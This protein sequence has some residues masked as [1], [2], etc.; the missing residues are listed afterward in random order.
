MHAGFSELRNLYG[1]NYIAKFTGNVP[2]TKQAEREI[3]RMLV[4]W[5]ECR[6]A[7][8][9]ILGEEGGDDGWLFGGFGIADAYFWPVYG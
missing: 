6:C 2:R 7:T 9:Q 5:G 3:E 8:V 4:L 1:T